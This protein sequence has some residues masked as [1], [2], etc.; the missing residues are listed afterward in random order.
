MGRG[1]HARRHARGRPQG[2]HFG[3]GIAAERRRLRGLRS[4]RCGGSRSRSCRRSRATSSP[5]RTTSRRAARSRE[6]GRR[7]SVHASSRATRPPAP[8]S[9]SSGST[10]PPRSP[11]ARTPACPASSTPRTSPIARRIA[12]CRR[13]TSRVAAPR[14]FTSNDLVARGFSATTD[15]R[16]DAD[17]RRARSASR[18]SSRTCT[19]GRAAVADPGRGDHR[20]P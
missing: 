11:A 12:T 2:A 9:R 10:R 3:L 13:R 16:L 6:Q 1:T 5:S 19:R 14:P 7:R 4:R 15:R 20:R 8:R 18:P 17:H